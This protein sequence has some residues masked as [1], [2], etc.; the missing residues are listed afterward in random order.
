M[1][2]AANGANGS[3]KLT[4]EQYLDLYYHMRLN[5]AVEGTMVKRCRQTRIVG[6][7]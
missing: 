4:R 7:L 1:A 6:G 5:R 3:R 2:K